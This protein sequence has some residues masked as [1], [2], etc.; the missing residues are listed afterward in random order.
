MW[1]VYELAP[2]YLLNLKKEK[3]EEC[4]FL[5]KKIKKEAALTGCIERTLYKCS[6]N[7]GI[8]SDCYLKIKEHLRNEN[9]IP[10][11]E[12]PFANLNIALADCP[13]FEQ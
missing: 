4:R 13:C 5:Y 10:N 2:P 11:G 9:I 1:V 3:M 7:D 8:D 12:C 6:K